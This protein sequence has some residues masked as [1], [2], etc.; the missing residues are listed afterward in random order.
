MKICK[1][2]GFKANDDWRMPCPICNQELEK[3]L[4]LESILNNIVS[5]V[6]KREDSPM[7]A[8]TH[9]D[10]AIA[11]LKALCPDWKPHSKEEADVVG[12]AEEHM[13]TLRPKRK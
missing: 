5:A 3:V 10:C 7:S 1:I 12:S 8:E 4:S 9:L 2:C 6:L 13:S 11:D